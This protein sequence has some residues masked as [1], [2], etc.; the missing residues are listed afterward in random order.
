MGRISNNLQPAFC[1]L[2]GQIQLAMASNAA[3]LES[4]GVFPAGSEIEL[5]HLAWPEPELAGNQGQEC[6]LD[7][8]DIYLTNL[9]QDEEHSD[10]LSI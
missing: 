9:D 8:V 3:G 4:S 6:L 1:S 5:A 7:M 10:L 2:K